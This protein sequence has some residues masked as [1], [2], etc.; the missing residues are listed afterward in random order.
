MLT[1]ALTE[2]SRYGHISTVR[3]LLENGV[4]V[5][6][7]NQHAIT[8]TSINGH[9]DVLREL[10][11]YARKG[12]FDHRSPLAVKGPKGANGNLSLV[13]LLIE[14]GANIHVDSDRPLY[15]AS[16]R[17]NVDVVEYLLSIS[18]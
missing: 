6:V 11:L 10:I 18:A 15:V 3:L 4:Y 1:K 13:K 8:A 7:D 12:S 5:R 17:N 14:R 2:A 9:V 16:D